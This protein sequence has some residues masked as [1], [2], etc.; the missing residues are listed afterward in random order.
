MR[1]L[2]CLVEILLCLGVTASLEFY[3]SGA[4]L[5]VL[6]DLVPYVRNSFYRV[7]FT[8][9]LILLFTG[10]KAENGRIRKFNKQLNQANDRLR[11]YAFELERMTEVRE[12][13]RLAREIHDILGH[14]L[15]GII[16]WNKM[17]DIINRGG[18]S[19]LI[20]V[21]RSTPDEAFDTADVQVYKGGRSFLVPAGTQVRLDPGESI[22]IYPY[23]YHDFEVVPGISPVLLGEVS[24]CNDD[25]ND[26]RFC[27]AGRPHGHL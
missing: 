2:V 18:G 15:T 9:A 1:L 7:C 24:M 17:K 22:S 25:E 23:L 11:D 19:I 14:T 12:R 3:Y 13:N 16:Y 21:Y 26:N 8:A 5:L 4:A 10:Q 27:P 6:A 20:R